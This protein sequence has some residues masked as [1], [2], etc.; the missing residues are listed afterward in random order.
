M[1][2]RVGFT[3]L[4]LLVGLTVVA[5]V[6]SVGTATLQIVG[7]DDRAARASTELVMRDAAIRRDII[8]WL[9]G[10]HGTLGAT[11]GAFQVIDA[12]RLGRD[13]DILIFTTSAPTPLG[14]S[15]T[16]VKLFIDDDRRTVETGL[17]AELTSWAG[18]P[19]MRL[20]LD[21]TMTSLDVRCLTS[22]LGSRQWVPSWASTS[23]V[24]RG[25]AIRL[26]GAPGR[27]IAP[28][29]QLP[30]VVAMEGGR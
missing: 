28:L 13:S 2:Q 16:T 17:T 23:L 29:L 9:E 30:I 10:A 26:R 24:P 20:E 1:R 18:G 5:L 7:A 6:A 15:E 12:T 11:P 21:S 3:M 27:A 4:E 25:V 14:T 19:S 8:A 22:L